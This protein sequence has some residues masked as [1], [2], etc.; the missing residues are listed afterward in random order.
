MSHE[1]MV[2]GGWVL[3][4]GFDALGDD[5]FRVVE[6][7]DPALHLLEGMEWPAPLPL[8]KK[9]LECLL[10]ETG[11]EFQHVEASG[12][13]TGLIEKGD[14]ALVVILHDL[15]KD[16]RQF[17]LCGVGEEVVSDPSFHLVDLLSPFLVLPD[18]D[19]VPELDHHS[20]LWK[21]LEEFELGATHTKNDGLASIV[22]FILPPIRE[23]VK[24]NG[25]VFH[26]FSPG[27]DMGLSRKDSPSM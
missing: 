3:Q 1:E 21:E 20:A 22:G 16:V 26:F 10:P 7:R 19:P 2:L 11:Q 4:L 13:T 23:V 8:I 17:S 9:M 25:I 12:D 18:I 27:W 14:K 6:G 5:L 15:L 24:D